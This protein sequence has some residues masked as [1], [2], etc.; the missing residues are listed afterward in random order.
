MKNSIN[1]AIVGGGASGIFCAI[2]LKA[3]SKDIRLNN[4]FFI[5]HL[6]SLNYDKPLC[7][8]LLHL[9]LKAKELPVQSEQALNA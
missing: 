2:A 8:L 7:R 6:L 3:K 4:S 1:I 5:P 9:N